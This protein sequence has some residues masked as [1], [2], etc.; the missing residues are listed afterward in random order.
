MDAIISGEIMTT[1]YNVT[2]VDYGMGNLGSLVNVCD[3]FDV[4]Y[5]ISNDAKK[6]LEAETIILPGVGSFGSAMKALKELNLI[7]ALREA[8]LVKN[9]KILGI[10]LGFQ[11][12]AQSSTEDG[13]TEGLGFIDGE[14]DCFD[15]LNISDKKKIHIGFNE[16]K[17]NSN[18]CLFN[19]IPKV[20][21]FYFV[22]SYCLLPGHKQSSEAISNYGIDFLAAYEEGN[23]FG[24]QFHPEK[25]QTNGIQLFKNFLKA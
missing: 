11:M 22:H 15:K 10:C 7:D 23:I 4:R 9:I 16:V 2:I 19:N 21:D 13:F 20:A 18:S 6:V 17:S 24:T 14:V 25:S 12:F 5:E 1:K 8:V 3:F